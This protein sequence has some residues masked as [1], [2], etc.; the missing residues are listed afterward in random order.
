MPQYQSLWNY[1][2]VKCAAWCRSLPLRSKHSFRCVRSFSSYS[3]RKK[4]SQEEFTLCV[5]SFKQTVFF[6]MLRLSR[7]TRGNSTNQ[8]RRHGT[9]LVQTKKSLWFADW[10]PMIAALIR[11]VYYA[12]GYIDSPLVVRYRWD[13]LASWATGLDDMLVMCRFTVEAF[14]E[15]LNVA[16][17]LCFSFFL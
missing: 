13:A 2:Q 6:H 11:T 12:K 4:Q 9:H 15:Q 5:S 8:P 16:D 3:N 7:D 14:L 1:T 17:C 10:A